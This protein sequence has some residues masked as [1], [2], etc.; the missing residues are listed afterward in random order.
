M[1]QFFVSPDMYLPESTLLGPNGEFYTSSG[2]GSILRIDSS[3]TSYTEVVY[4]G[5][6]PLGMAW[7]VDGRLLVANSLLGL[8]AVDL[9]TRSIEIL[10]NY[11]DGRQVRFAN[12]VTV[13]KSGL[14]YFTD[15][16]DVAPIHAANGYYDTHTT[17][18]LQILLANPTGRVI[19]YDPKNRVAT[20]IDSDYSFTNGIALSSNEDYLLVCDLGRNSIRRI[21]LQGENAG[22]SEVVVDNIPGF[23]D[24]IQRASD[25]GF[26]IALAAK[27][28]AI[29]DAVHNMPVVKRLLLRFPFSLFPKPPPVSQILKLSKDLKIEYVLADGTGHLPFVTDA[30]EHDGKLHLCAVNSNYWAILDLAAL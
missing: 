17:A 30:M 10:C 28:S 6:R 11:V 18:V 1:I 14:I 19:R 12:A 3:L 7:A 16:T 21:W 26:W 23:P 9:K 24:N 8:L 5:G 13:S 4:T 29:V 15:S 22:T 25:G 2:N 27:R 20:V